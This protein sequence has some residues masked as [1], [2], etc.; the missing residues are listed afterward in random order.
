MG[1]D[2]SYSTVAGWLNGSRGIRD[3]KHMRALCEALESDLQTLSGGELELSEKPLDVAISREIKG[4]TDAEKEAI[5]A[6]T[7]TMRS[8]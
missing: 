2:L 3:V 6:L 7:R 4:L 8:K 5:L 1:F